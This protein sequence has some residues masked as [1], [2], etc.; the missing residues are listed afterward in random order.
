MKY[1]KI[2]VD[3]LYAY[4]R[5]S[6]TEFGRAM[7]ALLQFVEDG[8]EPN[9][10]GKESMMFDV[11]REQVKR[12]QRAYDTK[13]QNGS[14]GGRPPKN[15][16]L[17]NRPVIS[18]TEKTEQNQDK[19]KDK[20]D[21]PPTPQGDDDEEELLAINEGHQQV[22]DKARDCGFDVNTA[23]LD[24]LTSLI[25]VHGSDA[26]IA[27]LDECV[28]SQAVNFRYLRAVLTGE[29]KQAP[30]SAGPTVPRLFP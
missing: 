28:D 19:D 27:A 22:F 16:N 5:L 4:R 8:T 18:E 7:R 11:L 24:R 17:K 12:D 9:L 10:P 29:K 13:V 26:V 23:T 25:A 2:Y 15:G 3:A 14:K 30:P 6:D 20:E 21:I 1:V